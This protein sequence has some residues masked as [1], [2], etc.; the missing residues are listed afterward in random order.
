MLWEVAGDG[1]DFHIPRDN[2]GKQILVFLQIS[3]H[4]QLYLMASHHQKIPSTAEPNLPLQLSLV[5]YGC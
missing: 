2:K 5:M 1:V 4:Q 3:C